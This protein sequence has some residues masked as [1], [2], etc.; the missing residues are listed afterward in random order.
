L[1]SSGRR[2]ASVVLGLVIGLASGAVAMAAPISV[3]VGDSDG[4]GFGAPNNGT[5]VLWPGA[6][7]TDVC[8]A[9]YPGSGPN[10]SETGTVL[11][12]FAGLLNSGTVTIA[13]GDFQAS[14]FTAINANINGNALPFGLQDGFQVTTVRVFPLTPAEIAAANL[15]GQVIL[16]FNHAGSVDFIA[17]D[18]FRLD[19]D[20]TLEPVP[21][22]ATLLLFG[23]TMMGLGALNRW[24]RRAQS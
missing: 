22:P 12:P 21:E 4:F 19:G 14:E 23:S 8:S 20:A 1:I 15:A 16:N 17:F 2:L 6:H 7:I 10:S 3:Q 24:R 18:F 13:M 11:L 9:L 5:G